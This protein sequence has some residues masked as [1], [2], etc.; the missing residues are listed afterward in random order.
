MSEIK[1][2]L[3]AIRIY[4]RWVKMTTVLV[5]SVIRRLPSSLSSVGEPMAGHVGINGVY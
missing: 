5:Q 3:V 2:R 4:G 1:N